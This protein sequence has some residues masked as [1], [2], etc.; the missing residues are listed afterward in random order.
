MSKAHKAFAQLQRR[1]I[2]KQIGQELSKVYAPLPE[3]L[4]EEMETL[5]IKLHITAS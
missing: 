3:K 2:F 4:P 1:A 5:L